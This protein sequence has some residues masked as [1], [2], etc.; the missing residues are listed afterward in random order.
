MR[1]R[2]CQAGGPT[3]GVHVSFTGARGAR[4]ILKPVH[5]TDVRPAAW[6]TPLLAGA[7]ELARESHDGPRQIKGP[8]LHHPRAV[9]ILL[10]E[11]GFAE[12]VVA[13]ALLHDVVEDSTTSLDEVG[14][15]FG[16]QVRSLVAA[17]TENEA[18][19]PYERRKAEHRERATRSRRVAAI[20]AA[21]KLAKLRDTSPAEPVPEHKLEHYRETL[22]ILTERHPHLPFLRELREELEWRLETQAARGT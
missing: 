14:R 9:A 19:E 20:Y 2:P 7:D 10:H 15:R 13:A 16:M 12:E 4:F 22:R 11:Q 6:D 5:A 1:L 8:G 21:D 18:I 3:G 17:M